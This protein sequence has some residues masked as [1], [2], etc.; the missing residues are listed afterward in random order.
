MAY[1]QIVKAFGASGSGEAPYQFRE[2]PKH[3]YPNGP[4]LPFVQVSSAE[5]EEAAM[6]TGKVSSADD[7]RKRL[8]AVAGQ[9][10]LKVDA[11]WGIDRIV[12]AITNAGY[13]ATHNP[14][15]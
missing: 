15:L 10:G 13:D 9:A 11:R 14:F 12:A 7:E 8:L 3:V 5:E 1:N 2:Y 6:A 4:E